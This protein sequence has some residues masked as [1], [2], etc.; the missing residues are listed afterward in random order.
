MADDGAMSEGMRVRGLLAVALLGLVA[1][2]DRDPV[3]AAHPATTIATIPEPTVYRGGGYVLEDAGGPARLCTGDFEQSYPPH[4]EGA[5]LVGWDWSAVDG[6]ETAGITRWGAYEVD[7]TVDGQRLV[8][9]E[10][11]PLPAASSDDAAFGDGGR[12]DFSTPCDEP[13]DG[14]ASSVD[15]SK[16]AF[17]DYTAFFAYLDAEPDRSAVWVDNAT[18][19]AFD[20]DHPDIYQASAVGPVTNIRVTRDRARHEAEVRAIWGG[21]I[22]V[23]EGGRSKAELLDVLEQVRGEVGA[24]SSG[25]DEIGGRADIGVLVADPQVQ[26]DL[27]ERYG[28]GTV[29][30]HP[31]LVPVDP[32]EGQDPE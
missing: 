15:Q 9:V 12:P 10:A 29:V 14:W 26:A 2:G 3:H 24:L 32:D 16:V 7:V 22:C 27:D 17:S 20:P 30:L 21:P 11:G 31:R 8:L 23:V 1:C 25:L 19:P 28:D 6:E 18:D 5:E 4:C 13:A